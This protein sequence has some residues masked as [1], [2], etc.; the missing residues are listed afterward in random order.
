[1]VDRSRPFEL[2]KGEFCRLASDPDT[3]VFQVMESLHSLDL[4][5]DVLES[6][7][8]EQKLETW[9]RARYWEE[10]SGTNGCD[11]AQQHGTYAQEINWYV[12]EQMPGPGGRDIE[13]VDR[14]RCLYDRM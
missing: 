10:Q 8:D 4:P 11:L 6:A 3:G 5:K 12:F 13:E 9:Y 2:Q 1:M 14:E 7:T